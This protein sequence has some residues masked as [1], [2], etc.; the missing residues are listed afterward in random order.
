MKVV[1]LFFLRDLFSEIYI[2]VVKDIYIY[3]VMDIYNVDCIDYD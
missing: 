2:I 1:Y 3:I